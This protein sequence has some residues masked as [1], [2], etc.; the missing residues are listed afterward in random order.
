MWALAVLL[1][2]QSTVVGVFHVH[3][4]SDF[5]PDCIICHYQASSAG[6]APTLPAAIVVLLLGFFAAVFV[7]RFRTIIMVYSQ[8]GWRRPPPV[9]S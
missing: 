7:P 4:S 9:F 5:Q 2:A 6:T 1:L 8:N 3:T